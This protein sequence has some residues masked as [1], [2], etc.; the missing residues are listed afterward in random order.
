MDYHVVLR[1]FLLFQDG[2]IG[3]VWIIK[4]FL[5]VMLA[6]PV[7]I[8]VVKKSPCYIVYLLM[9][10]LIV[11]EE[12]LVHLLNHANNHSICFEAINE[13]IPYLLGYSVF[14][15]LGLLTK[16]LNEEDERMQ[17]VCISILS[18]G[19]MGYWLFRNGNIWITSYKYP[20]Q[21]LYI[22]Y[23]CLMPALLWFLRRIF[24]L[25]ERYELIGPAK[26]KFI[27]YLVF[28]GQNTLWFYLWHIL[29]V[30]AANH[31]LTYWPLRFIVVLFM[32]TIVMVIQYKV[33][34]KIK[35]KSSWPIWDYFVG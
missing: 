15:L 30:I 7:L 11:A 24:N 32:S 21:L 27:D 2:S 4:V 10:V 31:F 22:I 34:M 8:K 18:I 26:Q 6:T 13:T 9:G 17:L 20:P 35:S 19:F 33:I 23:G 29:F 12:Y 25:N 3:Y 5:L 1:S 28:L 16:K 14:F